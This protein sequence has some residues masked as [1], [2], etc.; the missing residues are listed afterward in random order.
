MSHT[1]LEAIE[2]RRSIRLTGDSSLSEKEITDLVKQAF[3]YA[4]TAFNAQEYRAL[5]LFGAENKKF[6]ALVEE[7]VKPLTPAEFFPATQKKLAGFAGSQGTVLFFID[8]AVVRDLQEKFPLYQENFPVW[9]EQDQGIVQFITWTLLNEAGLGASLQHYNP[10]VDE[11]VIQHWGVDKN[12]RL[13]GQLPFG[14]PLE[15]AAPKTFA[16]VEQL[17]ISK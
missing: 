8:D 4:P 5:V 2:Q 13:R 11:D 6:W 10:L 7:R 16:D 1:F 12:W 3:T 15:Q 14:K 17:V 9:A